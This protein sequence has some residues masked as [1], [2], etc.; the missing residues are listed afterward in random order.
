[1]VKELTNAAIKLR[2][3]RIRLIRELLGLSRKSLAEKYKEYGL[4]AGTIASW[5]EGRWGGITE[6]G[7]QKLIK[8]FKDEGIDVS[9][10]WLLHGL[11][12]APN[13]PNF[14]LLEKKLEQLEASAVTHELKI[15][16]QFH[17]NAVDMIISD[18][19]MAP[20]LQPGDIVAGKKFFEKEI[21]KTIGLPCIVQTKQGHMY[22]R[23]VDIGNTADTYTLSC[24]NPYTKVA[25]S[26]IE[27]VE[28]F[29]SAP[30]I[31]IRKPD[32]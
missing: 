13:T 24:S 28:L 30:I 11:G 19:G 10:D 4:S 31:W 14:K 20:C 2:S 27:N 22:V 29:S 25:Q 26:V 12:Q 9:L 32:I 23:I 17:Q 5:E 15:F 18:D 1:M 21:R 6:K 8:A 7:A 16:H 3:E